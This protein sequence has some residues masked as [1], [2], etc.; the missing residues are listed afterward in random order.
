MRLFPALLKLLLLA[1]VVF[2]LGGGAWAMQAIINASTDIHHASAT[3]GDMPCHGDSAADA[4][5]TLPLHE[6]D[7]AKCASSTCDCGCTM[8]GSA[9]PMQPVLDVSLIPRSRSLIPD[10]HQLPDTF[11]LPGLRPPISA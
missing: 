3:E 1:A 9:L 2:D 6:H 5:D 10:G 8:A 7:D 4:V 11:A